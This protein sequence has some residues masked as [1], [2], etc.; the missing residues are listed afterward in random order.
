MKRQTTIER[1]L[2]V[3]IK[4]QKK[5]QN[6]YLEVNDEEVK[7]ARRE[8]MT[9]FELLILAFDVCVGNKMRFF[10]L[11]RWKDEK[12]EWCPFRKS[13]YSYILSFLRHLW[14]LNI[15]MNKQMLIYTSVDAFVG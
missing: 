1:S 12:L 15:Q 6:K 7:D 3:L 11:M 14:I 8:M 5:K 4:E 9:A 13:A 2:F 10:F